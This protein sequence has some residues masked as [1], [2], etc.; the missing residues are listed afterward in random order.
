LKPKESIL[1]QIWKDPV[2]IIII[3]SIS[4]A[5]IV[6]AVGMQL[7][8][9][10]VIDNMMMKYWRDIKPED[11]GLEIQNVSGFSNGT[12]F[13]TIKNGGNH[14]VLIKEVILNGP[15]GSNEEVIISI[16]REIPEHSS[17]IIMSVWFPKSLQIDQ[18]YTVE[19]FTQ[20]GSY[21]GAFSPY[22][23]LLIKT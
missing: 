7:Q 23:I 13:L 1:R 18:H 6:L 9:D 4:G 17:K 8:G 20:R 21:I 10:F 5:I 15:W 14:S 12:V 2:F 3:V 19:F 22:S 11:R 16:N